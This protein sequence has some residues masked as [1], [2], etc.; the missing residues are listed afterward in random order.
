MK[1]KHPL[2]HVRFYDN[3][4]LDEGSFMLNNRTFQSLLPNEN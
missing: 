4:N 2:N 1:D 3:K